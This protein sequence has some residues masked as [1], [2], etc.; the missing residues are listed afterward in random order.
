MSKVPVPASNDFCPQTLFAYGT[1]R[2]D[3]SLEQKFR[4][5]APVSTTCQTYFS[6]DGQPMGGWGEEYR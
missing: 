3:G 1:T 4:D 2:A 5:I 6:W